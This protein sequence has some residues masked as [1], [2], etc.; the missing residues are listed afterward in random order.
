MVDGVLEF[1]QVTQIAIARLGL[2][3][4]S[5]LTGEEDEAE[6]DFRGT[7]HVNTRVLIVIFGCLEVGFKAMLY[8]NT[9]THRSVFCPSPSF[10][11]SYHA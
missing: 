8:F 10:R 11:A 3:S 6:M 2:V 4:G 1:R 5:E 7:R 9:I